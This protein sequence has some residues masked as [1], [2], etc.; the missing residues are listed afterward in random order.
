MAWWNMLQDQF[1]HAVSAA[2]APADGAAKTE[3]HSET[4]PAAPQAEAAPEEKAQ[5]N[6]HARARSSKPKGDKA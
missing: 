2:M 5:P 6:G 4:P 3:A 1:T